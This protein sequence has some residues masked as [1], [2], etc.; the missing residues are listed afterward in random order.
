V[1]HTATL[2]NGLPL[3]LPGAEAERATYRRNEPLA[4]GAVLA[5]PAGAIGIGFRAASVF[6]SHCITS[7]WRRSAHRHSPDN[8]RD[9]PA[10]GPCTRPVNCLAA[11]VSQQASAVDFLGISTELCRFSRPSQR[12]CRERD[13]YR[14]GTDESSGGPSSQLTSNRTRSVMAIGLVGHRGGGVVR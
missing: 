5:L 1:W 13:E 4:L 8:L 9:A 14:G 7:F 11:T 12:P 10:C 2:C 3:T 6:I